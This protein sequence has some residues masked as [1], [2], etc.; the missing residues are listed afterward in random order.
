MSHPSI[1]FVQE[2]PKCLQ[3]FP[4]KLQLALMRKGWSVTNLGKHLNNYSAVLTYKIATGEKSPTP[5]YV[6]R[7]ADILGVD[8]DFRR[9]MHRA[10]AIDQGWKI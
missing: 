5:Y 3:Q 2:Q 4:P 7:V 1:K 9:E 8:G 6:D 10:G